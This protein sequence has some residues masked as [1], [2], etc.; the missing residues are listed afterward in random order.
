MENFVVNRKHLVKLLSNSLNFL[1]FFFGSGRLSDTT[2]L[3]PT[4]LHIKLGIVKK[5]SAAIDA[6]VLHWKRLTNWRKADDELVCPALA[7]LEK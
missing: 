5:F 7:L 6:V 3:V 4:T 1:R 2:T